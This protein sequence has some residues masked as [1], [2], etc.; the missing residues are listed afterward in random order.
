MKHTPQMRKL[1]RKSRKS[2]S[3]VKNRNDCE[4]E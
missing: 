3:C 4:T 1:K 2:E